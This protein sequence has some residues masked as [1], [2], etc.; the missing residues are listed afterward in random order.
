MKIYVVPENDTFK[1]KATAW[2][3]NRLTDLQDIWN[4][5]KKEIVIIAP[6]AL[7]AITKITKSVNKTVNLR[8]EEFLKDRRIY[9]PKLGHYWELNRKLSNNEYLEIEY[10]KSNGETVGNI[11]RSMGVLK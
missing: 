1:A 8:Q 5:N 3:K 6:I 10:R 7:A 11:L 2:A 9:D 4:Q